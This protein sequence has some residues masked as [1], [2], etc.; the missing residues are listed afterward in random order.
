MKEK[1]KADEEKA[2]EAAALAAKIAAEEAANK[3]PEKYNDAFS[4]ILDKLES[5]PWTTFMN[6]PVDV[7]KPGGMEEI[8]KV[9]KE[10]FNEVPITKDNI[11]GDDNS[12][13]FFNKFKFKLNRKLL[14]DDPED[15]KIDFSA[16]KQLGKLLIGAFNIE[17]RFLYQQLLII[18][19]QKEDAIFDYIG[20]FVPELPYSSTA[21]S[22]YI[23]AKAKNQ[24]S[25]DQMKA[26]L[27]KQVESVR[28]RI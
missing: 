26:N 24:A 8:E 27:T 7:S 12:Q 28:E 13:T 5:R 2:A 19:A 20:N 6:Y 11:F 17:A 4:W 21:L 15:A 1:A 14:L 3:I 25:P 22:Y 10:N 9:V 16:I 18:A 23:D